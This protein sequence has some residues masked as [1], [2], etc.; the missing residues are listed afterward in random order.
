M[1]MIAEFREITCDLL[2][3]LIV[4]PSLIEAVLMAEVNNVEDSPAD[5]SNIEAFLRRLPSQQQSMMRQMMSQMEMTPEKLAH[6]EAQF[7][8][9][10]KI[11][12]QSGA[13][14]RRKM[15]SGGVSA[16]DLGDQLSLE[17]AWHG[18]HFLLCGK[19][20][21]APMPLGQA[22]LGGTEVGADRGYGPARYLKSAQVQDIS[23]ALSSVE[24][25]IL[26]Q[27]F[28]PGVLDAVGVYPDGWDEPD[29]I[30]WLLDSFDDLLRFYARVAKR[31][32]AVLLYL[33]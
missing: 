3:R 32:N 15:T 33:S 23:K 26:K 24:R 21:D 13:K 10:A 11:M 7:A 4:D 17:K 29:R 2:N 18:V 28:D 22:V 16:A 8:P 19:V 25:N 12:I 1:S 14:A 30:D 9:F 20:D 6:M 27:R 31:G 5:E